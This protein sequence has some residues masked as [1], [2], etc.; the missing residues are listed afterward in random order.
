MAGEYFPCP[1]QEPASSKRRKLPPEE[2]DSNRQFVPLTSMS[3]SLVIS[4]LD[5]PN[6]TKK[7]AKKSEQRQVGAVSR[8]PQAVLHDILQSNGLPIYRVS[9]SEA[10]Y[11]TL[12]SQL[13]L[14]SYGIAVIK[15]MVASDVAA[16][17][18]LLKAGLSPN[19]CN[20]FRDSLLDYVCKTSNKAAFH[21]FQ[22]NEADLR[23]CDAFG[24][25]PLHYCAW[26]DTFEES[27]VRAILKKDPQQLY[28]EDKQGNTP[29]EFVSNSAA[30]DWSI[31]LLNE[32]EKLFRSLPAL[33]NMEHRVQLLDPPN[34]LSVDS[35]KA[36]SSGRIAPQDV[37]ARLSSLAASPVGKRL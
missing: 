31:F 34:S 23:V 1:P 33:Q 26:S 29:L 24:R 19:P 2:G 21:C 32:K 35:A 36:V 4:T 28:Q 37:S 7:Q 20:Q 18:A 8:T 11:D 25:T 14:A 3:P 16:L 13:Q 6:V 15:S 22:R 30:Q 5:F 10:K 9:A 27:I 17:D 12:P